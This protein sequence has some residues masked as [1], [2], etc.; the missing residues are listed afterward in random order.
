MKGLDSRLQLLRAAF[1]AIPALH[2]R[3][4]AF[5]SLK[6]YLWEPSGVFNLV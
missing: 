5:G 4:Q 1:L 3:H 2:A 6:L